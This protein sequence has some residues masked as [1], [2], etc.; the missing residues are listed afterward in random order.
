MAG[1]HT[2]APAEQPMRMISPKQG[3][4]KRV[5]I[6]IIQKSYSERAIRTESFK[7]QKYV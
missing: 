6:A 1:L 7:C 5:F 2:D 4:Q 3:L